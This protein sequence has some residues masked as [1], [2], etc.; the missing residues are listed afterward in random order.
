MIG[1]YSMHELGEYAS[2]LELGL[3]LV[4]SALS[5]ARKCMCTSDWRF[6]RMGKIG[7]Y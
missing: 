2:S 4:L 6:R 3:A 1:F 7:L 5:L